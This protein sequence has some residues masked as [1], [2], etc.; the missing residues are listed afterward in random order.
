MNIR[1]WRKGVLNKAKHRGAVL[2]TRRKGRRAC[3]GLR[4]PLHWPKPTMMENTIARRITHTS[5]QGPQPL[6][7]GYQNVRDYP[8]WH[9]PDRNVHDVGMPKAIGLLVMHMVRQVKPSVVVEVGTAFGISGMYFLAATYPG[10]VLITF[11][12]NGVWRDLAI[13]NL[14]SVSDQF[15]SVLGTFED[16]ISHLNGRRIDFAFLDAIHTR[17]HVMTQYEL[18]LN[19]ASAECVVLVDD[20]NFSEDMRRCWEELLQRPEVVSAIDCDDRLGVL[21]LRT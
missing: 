4:P 13:S 18:V 5:E 21:Q 10:A 16:N 3:V 17:D 15:E 1:S 11:E 14:L 6:W 7:R 8:T 2:I 12:P 9:T 19:H 20:I